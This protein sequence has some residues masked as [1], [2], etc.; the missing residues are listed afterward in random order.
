LDLSSDEARLLAE[1]GFA[2]AGHGLGRQ[3]EPIFAALELWRPQ[4]AAAGTGRALDALSRGR[5]EEAVWFLRRQAL[6]AAP[7]DRSALV[8]LGVALDRAGHKHESRCLLERLIEA[9]PSDSS[10][11]AARALLNRI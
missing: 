6:S 1:I 11:D 8:L 10:A 2:A 9:D 4:S 3:A 5:P 7:D